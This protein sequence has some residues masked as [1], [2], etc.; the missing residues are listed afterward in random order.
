MKRMSNKIHV[1]SLREVK[2]FRE[3]VNQFRLQHANFIDGHI[4]QISKWIL[5]AHI[6][7]GC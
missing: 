1:F 6:V 5:R 4:G 7:T 3:D 2:E